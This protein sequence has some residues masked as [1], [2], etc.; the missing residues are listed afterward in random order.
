MTSAPVVIPSSSVQATTPVVAGTK[1][2]FEEEEAYRRRNNLR[3]KCNKKWGFDHKCKMK[4][5]L[6]LILD[7]EEEDPWIDIGW[8]ERE[9]KSINRGSTIIVK[10]SH[11]VS[12]PQT[13]RTK[14]LIQGVGVT[15]LIDSGST[16]NFIDPRMVKFLKLPLVEGP[17]FTVK[18]ANGETVKSRG[19]CVGVLLHFSRVYTPIDFLLLKLAGCDL[20]L[21]VQ[22]LCSISP[23][24]WDCMEQ[25]M[26]LKF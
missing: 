6:F 7:A 3:F 4:G 2:L 14:V 19:R 11:R 5:K 8:T 20:V 12:M 9:D 21:G 17:K 13:M 24:Q 10:C 18:V 22:W 26:R 15:T 23:V 16:H 25:E 1:R